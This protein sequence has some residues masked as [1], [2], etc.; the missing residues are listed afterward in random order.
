MIKA[1]LKNWSMYDVHCNN[2]LRC[3]AEL[4]WASPET[5]VELGFKE[6]KSYDDPDIVITSRV[7]RVGP[8]KNGD[9]LLTTVNSTYL[10]Q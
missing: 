4:V 3:R 1:I 10:L 8:N 6:Y 2:E 5:R 7:V 9:M